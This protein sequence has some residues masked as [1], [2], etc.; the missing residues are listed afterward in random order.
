MTQHSENDILKQTFIA[1]KKTQKRLHDLESSHTESIAVV[2]IGCRLPGGCNSPDLFWNYLRNKGIACTPIPNDRWDSEAYYDSESQTSGTTNVAHANF[3][4]CPVY[5]FDAPFFN[6]SAKETKSLDPQQRILLEVAWE[7]FEEGC[8]DITKFAGSR[9]GVYIGISSD[10]YSQA[11]RHS[12]QNDLIDSYSLTGTC[13][14]PAAGRISYTFGFEGPCMAID[15][16]CSSSLVALHLACQGLRTGESDMA[17]AGGVNLI[18]SPILHICSTKLGTISPDGRCK[19]FDDSADGY[20]RGEGCGLILLK[21]LSDA[22]RDGNRIFA[23][24]RGTAVN[25]DG[26]S[27]GLTAPN[28][29]SQE[30]VIQSALKNANLSPHDIHYIEAHG[31]GTPLGDP[32][33][34]ESIARVMKDRDKSNPIIVGSVKANIGHLEA[35]AGVSGVLKVIQSLRHEQI[36]PHVQLTRLNHLVAWDEIPIMVPVDG[37]EWRKGNGVRRAGI[38][39]FGFSGTNAHAIVEEAPEVINTGVNESGD[40][41][42]LHLLPLSARSKEALHDLYARYTQFFESNSDHVEHACY[43]AGVGRAHLN[44]RA[45]VMGR[46]AKTLLSGLTMLREGTRSAQAFT[47]GKGSVSS[48]SVAFLFTGQGSQYIGMGRGLYDAH[49]VFRQA[50]ERCNALLQPLLEI[51]LLDLLY[52]ESANGET[53]A[54][55]QYTQPAIFS[56]QYALVQLWESWG[57]VPD[58]VAGHSIGEYAAA[59]CAGVLSLDDAIG[60]VVQRG[61]LMQAL[62]SNGTMAAVF[63]REELVR[64]LVEVEGDAAAIATINAPENVVISGTEEAVERVVKRLQ[65][66]GI[67]SKPLVVSHAFHSSLMEPMLGDFQNAAEKMTFSKPQITMVSTVTGEVA[68]ERDFCTAAYWTEQIR[69]PVRFAKTVQTLADRDVDIFLE[70]GSMPTLTQFARSTVPSEVRLYLP[71]LKKGVDDWETMLSS[72]GQCYVKGVALDWTGFDKPYNREKVSLPTYPFQRKEYYMNPVVV[73]GQPAIGGRRVHPHLGESILS[74]C[75]PDD[76]VLFQTTFTETSPSF[77]REHLIFDTIISPGAAHLSM[78]LSAWRQIAS[79]GPCML[80]HVGLTAPLTLREEE[81]RT[82]QCTIKGVG[83]SSPTFALISRLEG[84]DVGTWT[85]HCEGQYS[86]AGDAPQREV[87]LLDEVRSRCRDASMTHEQLYEYL[88][89]SGYTVGPHFKCIRAIHRGDGEAFCE[90]QAASTIHDKA[91][92][93]GM[94]DS[95]LQTVLPAMNESSATLLEGD[96]VL[97]PL[98]FGAVCSYGSLSG[99]LKTYTRVEMKGEILQC[100]IC[101]WNSADELVF[102]IRDFILK[103]TNRKTLFKTLADDG[104]RLLYAT[105]WSERQVDVL[106]E[107]ESALK[108]YPAIVLIANQ[109]AW[110]EQFISTCPDGSCIGLYAG[111]VS[112]KMSED[113]YS[114]DLSSRGDLALFLQ[115]IMDQEKDLPVHI[116]YA[117][118]VGNPCEMAGD[119]ETLLQ[120]QLSLCDGVYA[121]VQS[122][123]SCNRTDGARLWLL[124]QQCQG[125]FAEDRQLQPVARSLWGLGRTLAQE[126]PEL[127]GGLIDVEATLSPEGVSSLLSFV[128]GARGER[129]VALRQDRRWFVPRL[130]SLS[131]KGKEKKQKVLPKKSSLE[132]YFLDVGNRGTLDELNFKT[133]ARRQPGV[134]EVEVQ[135]WASGLN[136]RDVLNVLGRY[137]GDAGCMGYEASGTVVRVG[138]GVQGYAVGDPVIVMD[139]PGCIC[140]YITCPQNAIGHKPLGVSPH[141]AVTIPATFLTA[142]YGLITLA[143]LKKGD[144]VLIHAGSGGVG[145]AAIQ[146]AKSVGAEI[147]ATAGTDEKRT[148]LTQYGVD[149]VFHSRTLDFADEIMDVTKGKGVDVVLNSLAGDFIEKSFSVLADQGRFVEIGKT[150]IWND[151]QVRQYNPTLRYFFF[152]L[153]SVAKENPSVIQDLYSAVCKRFEEKVFVPLPFTVFSMEQAKDAFRFMAQG[154]HIGKIVLSRE[155]EIVK[156]NVETAGVVRGDGTYLVTGGLGALGLLFARWLAD[157]GA[158]RVVLIGRSAVKSSAQAAIQQMEKTGTQ[159]LVKNLD[160]GNLEAV[161]QLMAEINDADRPLR[162]ILHSAGVL[163]DGMLAEQNANRLTQVMVPKVKGAYHLHEATK[164]M[165]LDFFVLFS[166]VVTVI[167]NLGQSNYAAANAFMDGFAAFRRRLGYPCTA[168]NWGPWGDVGMAASVVVDRFSAQGIRNIDPEDGVRVLKT[169][170]EDNCVQPTV[171]DVDWTHYGKAH[172]LDSTHGLFAEV[173]KPG[174]RASQTPTDAGPAKKDLAALIADVSESEKRSIVLDY[175]RTL[176]QDVL[177]YSD[178]DT[179]AVDQPLVDQGFDSLMTVDMRNRLSK[180]LEKTLP[181]SLL[182]DY[183]TLEKIAEYLFETV[184]PTKESEEKRAAFVDAESADSLLKEIEDLVK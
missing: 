82:V 134:G 48:P 6:I 64:P 84:E 45:V 35:S 165:T 183:P 88:E 164:E 182:F 51:S 8:L 113:T 133:R 70:I 7:T 117:L 57:V 13:F 130:Q 68:G 173:I 184:L 143:K 123:Q 53:L 89:T 87:P 34:I 12:C 159:I 54:Q 80:E 50:M 98:Q 135:V 76:T 5:Q 55:T 128:Q 149:H 171:F 95:F 22:Q 170:L 28:G 155:N 85:T 99:A 118:G 79:D 92:H 110:A 139:A 132:A 59:C 78:A 9:T 46:D 106:F 102:E 17:L 120:E 40:E 157:E 77:L 60:L 176:T 20:G 62:P 81:V 86:V 131:K 49:P 145:M 37:K 23:I 174:S 141:E 108:G 10:D 101:V 116:L 172:D 163:D 121:V 107:K 161:N 136:F 44:Y 41:R 24:I 105:S 122:L 56:I 71:S 26:K 168:I 166:S 69:K 2:G 75:L 178:A 74:P 119:S 152:D 142:Y 15:T 129:E 21:R 83:T 93:P 175:L 162:G 100:Q 109:N 144:R 61:A 146:I 65:G 127:W 27:N 148:F 42:P 181:A 124:T 36:P 158:G 177:G 151:E 150:G 33:E 112:K 52:G 67:V 73:S 14:A 31:T 4:T 125:V 63:C 91:I 97:I 138:E 160:I 96:N 115:E 126:V 111:D 39:S 30:K 137:P 140:D 32:I 114:I 25:Q 147:F 38:S 16:A 153:A 58:Y 66:I 167:G 29:L 156:H 43:S 169:I 47:S 18:L 180:N 3:L 103:H 90:V 179:I 11:H 72:A 94:I 154:K 19:T 1:L 104:S